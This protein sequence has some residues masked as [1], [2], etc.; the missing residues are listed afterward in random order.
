L[1]MDW[2]IAGVGGNAPGWLDMEYRSIFT[3]RQIGEGP[4]DQ[5]SEVAI[6]GINRHYLKP[7]MATI[8]RYQTSAITVSWLPVRDES[9][10]GKFKRMMSTENSGFGSQKSTPM[11]MAPEVCT[12]LSCSNELARLTVAT[13]TTFATLRLSSGKKKIAVNFGIG[14]LA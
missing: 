6:Q 8:L 5:R 10:V 13:G 3:S 7:S 12:G 14:Q 4:G 2:R 11:S 9:G 1:R